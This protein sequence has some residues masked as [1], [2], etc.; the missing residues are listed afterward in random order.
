MNSTLLV[1]PNPYCALNAKGEP[2]GKIKR[3][4]SVDKA[5]GFVGCTLTKGKTIKKYPKGDLRS[6]VHEF[7]LVFSVEPVSLPNTEYYRKKVRTG[8][9]IAA[10]ASTAGECAVKFAPIE[11]ALSEAKAKAIQY[12]EANDGFAPAIASQSGPYFEPS[13]AP[14]KSTPNAA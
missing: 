14:P 6:N 3:D 12:F 13:F 2:D 4:P 9:L 11:Q 8:E 10:D 1:V 7:S 5:G